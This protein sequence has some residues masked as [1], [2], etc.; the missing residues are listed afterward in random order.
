MADPTPD[1]GW[2]VL[3]PYTPRADSAARGYEGWLREVDNPFFNGVGGIAHYANW[4][5][6]R[7]LAGEPGFT[8]FDLMRFRTE[9]DIDRAWSDSSL[10]AFAAG[11]VAQWGVDPEAADPAVNYHAHVARRVSG[12]PGDDP[13]PH[14]LAFDPV[15]T[16]ACDELWEIARP[17]V[18][19]PRFQRFAIRRGPAPSADLAPVILEGRL[20]AAP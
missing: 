2:M 4:A 19:V 17:I 8:H 7:T 18:G 6:A 15:A 1:C 9:A 20:I 14:F 16:D 13:A 12:T 11:W 10:L 5:V 3:L